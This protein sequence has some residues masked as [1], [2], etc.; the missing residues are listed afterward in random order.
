MP[1]YQGH[2][3]TKSSTRS[4]GQTTNTLS[5]ESSNTSCG[6]ALNANSHTAASTPA[7]TGLR[8]DIA[9]TGASG[10]NSW[11]PPSCP[12]TRRLTSPRSRPPPLQQVRGSAH[13]SND[14]A[15]PSRPSLNHAVPWQPAALK[16][17]R[18]SATDGNGLESGTW[19]G[20]P[21]EKPAEA[22]HSSTSSSVALESGTAF[23]DQLT[24]AFCH[25]PD[26]VPPPRSHARK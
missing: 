2:S 1:D 17:A 3:A 23:S 22:A 11:L 24:A 18:T 13:F 14:D 25:R 9:S 16:A 10:S 5:A 8:N 19:T 26:T 7:P 21:R 20:T 6:P 12:A 4:P 15:D